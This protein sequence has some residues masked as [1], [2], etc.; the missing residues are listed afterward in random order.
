MNF[1]GKATRPDY[2][3]SPPPTRG[4]LLGSSMRIA[5]PTGP[6]WSSTPGRKKQ[7]MVQFLNH[8][9]SV[10][11]LILRLLEIALLVLTYVGINHIG[12]GSKAPDFIMCALFIGVL[13][14]SLQAFAMYQRQR[15][16]LPALIGRLVVTY[17]CAG[18]AILGLAQILPVSLPPLREFALMMAVSICISFWLRLAVPYLTHHLLPP[19]RI[20]VVGKDYLARQVIGV[21]RSTDPLEGIVLHG[22]YDPRSGR[23]SGLGAS[24]SRNANLADIVQ[25]ENIGEI[26]VAT[27]EQ[28]GLPLAEL[29]RFKLSGVQVTDYADFLEREKRYLAIDSLR[30][31]WLLFSDGFAHGPSRVIAK[32]LFDIVVSSGLLLLLSPFLLVAMV[33]IFLESGRPI[34]FRQDRVGF[35]GKNFTVLKLRSMVVDAETNGVPQWARKNDARVT[36]VGRLLRLTRID[37]IP[38]LLSVLH[39]DMS[40]VGPRP[41]REFFVRQ[42]RDKIPFYDLRHSVK[43]GLSGWAQVCYPYGASIDD[44]RAKLRFDLYYIKN[45]SLLLDILILLATVRIVIFGSGAR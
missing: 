16:P 41:E 5:Q 34:F 43:P 7:Q 3:A 15:S 36:R 4:N 39:G 35:A 19:M 17:L 29:L 30:P 24:P 14:M 45:H 32:R 1:I 42:L 33:A 25:D 6:L 2:D 28:R 21:L 18:I 9:I 23:F 44:A 26:V 38:Q 22:V 11:G 8:F 40:F 12:P 27:A 20:L 10:R 37:E 13:L 31:S